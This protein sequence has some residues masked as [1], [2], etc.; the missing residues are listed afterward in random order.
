MNR[1]TSANVILGLLGVLLAGIEIGK[2]AA[3]GDYGSAYTL[4]F[5]AIAALVSGNVSAVVGAVGG[6]FHRGSAVAAPSPTPEPAPASTPQES[7]DAA[8]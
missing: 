8:P 5:G 7:S 4:T 6:L 2:T 3:S 1:V